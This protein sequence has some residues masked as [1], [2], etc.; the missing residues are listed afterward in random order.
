[1]CSMSIREMQNRTYA[2][3]SL[4]YCFEFSEILSSILSAATLYY[5]IIIFVEIQRDAVRQTSLAPRIIG[6]SFICI[7]CIGKLA[8]NRAVTSPVLK[9]ESSNQ[10][11][12]NNASSSSPYPWIRR[13]DSP[14]SVVNRSAIIKKGGRCASTNMNA[15]LWSGMFA[16]MAPGWFA[17]ALSSLSHLIPLTTYLKITVWSMFSWSPDSRR[18][19]WRHGFLT[20]TFLISMLAIQR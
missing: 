7:F 19:V 20:C 4:F 18:T 12:V 16:L 10:T 17:C 14:H 9:S 1:M 2:K 3:W 5:I 6:G 13:H 11:P 15:V 8:V